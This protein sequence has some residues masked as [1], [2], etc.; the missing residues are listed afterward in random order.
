MSFFNNLFSKKSSPDEQG[1]YFLDHNHQIN[2][3]SSKTTQNV[4]NASSHTEADVVPDTTEVKPVSIPK[5]NASKHLSEDPIYGDAVARSSK[6]ADN[7]IGPTKPTSQLVDKPNIPNKPNIPPLYPE[8]TDYRVD[9]YEEFNPKRNPVRNEFARR[10]YTRPPIIP[11]LPEKEVFAFVIENSSHTFNQAEN[12]LN[13]VSQTVEKKKEAIFLFIKV[14]N[15]QTPFTPMDYNSVK[16][17]NIISSLLSPSKVDNS[18]NLAS[19][20]FYLLNNM[21]VFASDTFLFDQTKYKLAS[22]SIVCIGTGS[23]LQTEES[24]KII[25]S[26]IA[27]LQNISKLKT[28][29]YFCIKDSDAIRVS[30]LGFPVIGHIISNF[31]E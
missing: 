17:K 3:D 31:Y 7:N 22:C 23:C 5:E 19:A 14:G 21:N 2:S 27:R 26:C 28:F 16:E 30:S 8:R 6:P 10:G 24:L 29:K 11:K 13:I 9:G 12:I 18:P 15:E 20:L 25:S 1:P 4:V